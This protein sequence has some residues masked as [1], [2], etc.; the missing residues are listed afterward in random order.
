MKAEQ[1]RE[2][3][4]AKQEKDNRDIGVAVDKQVESVLNSIKIRSNDGHNWVILNMDNIH[5]SVINRL[6][7]LGYYFED[8]QTGKALIKW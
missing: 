1:A 6:I 8:Y 4:M 3:R 2:I 7:Y 5:Y